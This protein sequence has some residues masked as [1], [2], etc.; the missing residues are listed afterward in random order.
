MDGLL[1]VG[2]ESPLAGATLAI[3]GDMQFMQ[4]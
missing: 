4:R 3:D 2:H 1:V